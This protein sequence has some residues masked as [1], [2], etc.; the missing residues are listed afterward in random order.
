MWKILSWVAVGLLAVAAF[1]SHKNV[2]QFRAERQLVDIA[3]ANAQQAKDHLKK[4]EEELAK[5]K[6]GRKKT[7][8]ERDLLEKQIGETKAKTDDSVKQIADKKTELE[9]VTAR[10]A[11]AKEKVDQ[12]GGLQELKRKLAELQQEKTNLDEEVGNLKQKTAIAVERTNQLVQRIDTMKTREAWQSQGIVEDSFRSRIRSVDNNWG[13]VV[14][15]GGDRSGVVTGATLDVKRGGRVIG[16]LR[17]TNVEQNR[18]VADIIKGSVAEGESVAPGDTVTI[19]RISS[20][21]QWRQN[22]TAVP[23]AQPPQPG[24]PAATPAGGVAPP[25]APGDAP[26]AAPVD[27]FADPNA[28]PPSA[29]PATPGAEPTAPGTAPA[30]PGTPPAKPPNPGANPFGN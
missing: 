9:G 30:T 25:P 14:I 4:T 3:R 22:Q 10:W 28:P 20:A 11:A 12:G 21:S 7:E 15:D 26:P 16:Q 24:Q 5:N 6:T 8:D 17:V 18:A 23:A 2:A 13:F 19:S 1:F 27:P 29:P